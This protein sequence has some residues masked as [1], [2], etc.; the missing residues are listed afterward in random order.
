MS[1]ANRLK[2]LVIANRDVWVEIMSSES[3][4]NAQILVAEDPLFLSKDGIGELRME[5]R[6]DFGGIGTWLA[7]R[8]FGC[9][10]RIRR[11]YISSV[12]IR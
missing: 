3:Q 7:N 12:L 6:Q 5:L 10:I 1:I 4:S 9:L 8:Y 11:P 2:L